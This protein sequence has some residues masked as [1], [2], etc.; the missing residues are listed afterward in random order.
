VVAAKLHARMATMNSRAILN[1]GIVAGL[2]LQ[3][4]SGCGGSGMSSDSTST[5]N[6]GLTD[7]PVDG[8]Q[9]VWIQFTGVEVKPANGDPVNF[10]FSP[11]KGFDLLTLSGGATATFL[12]GATIPAGPYEWVRLMIDPSPGSSYI[13][14]SLGTQHNLVI[15]SGAESGLKLI[16]G[17]TMP[18]GGI[19]NFT[20]DFVLSKSIIAPPGQSPDFKLKPVLRL[21]DNAQVGTIS[22]TIQTAALG[23]PQ[24]NCGT[25]APVVYLFAGSGVTPDDIYVP[26]SGTLPAVQPLV[27][28]T[29]T[30]D[31]SS[32]FAY[33]I[34]FVPAGTYTVAF[35][36]DADDPAVD[37]TVL[38]PPTVVFTTYS[39]DVTVTNNMTTTVNF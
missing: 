13:I 28:A 1:C 19:A 20:V 6:L 33:T 39:Q 26:D 23:S 8:A 9:K 18:A 24:T 27:T 5:L 2:A 22:G 11:A 29:A 21:V 37:E 38:V 17:F 34:A 31:A 4:L 14:D 12:N 32:M 25:H 35:T 30:L 10:A 15:P 16:H 7:S 36:C 3:M